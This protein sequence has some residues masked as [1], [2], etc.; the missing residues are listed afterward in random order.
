MS[1]EGVSW[2]IGARSLV[3]LT[4]R[5][6]LIRLGFEIV[7]VKKYPFMSFSAGTVAK[8][9]FKIFLSGYRSRLP[10]TCYWS[11][12]LSFTDTYIR[13]RNYRET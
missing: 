6:L 3:D 4:V 1:R 8:E 2:I 5:D 9:L 11:K 12:K 10:S 13:A 7:L